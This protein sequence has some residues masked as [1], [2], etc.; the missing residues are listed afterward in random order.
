MPEARAKSIALLS[1]I[2]PEKLSGVA[3]GGLAAYLKRRSPGVARHDRISGAH[4]CLA[5]LKRI[6]GKADSGLKVLCICLVNLIDIP[7]DINQCDP[8]RIKDVEAVEALRWSHV[9]LVTEAEFER[10]IRPPLE[11]IQGE[12][13]ERALCDAG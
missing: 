12:E 8:R 11:T 2:V 5:I 1:R 9:P 10:Q 4:G 3:F 7:A 13:I 6:P